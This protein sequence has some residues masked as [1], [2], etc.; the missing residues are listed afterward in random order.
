[1]HPFLKIEGLNALKA[2]IQSKPEISISHKKNGFFVVCALFSDQQT[3]DSFYARECRGITFDISGNL[4]SR[5]LHKFFNLNE[6]KEYT[7]DLIKDKSVYAI[8]EKLDGS[9]IHT[10]NMNG[11]VDFKSKNSFESDVCIE[12]RKFISENVNYY[13]FCEL[14]TMMGLTAIFEYCSPSSRVVINYSKPSLTLL[15]VRDN[16]TGKYVLID[17]DNSVYLLI[18]EY[19]I[20]LVKKVNK[21]FDEI[22]NNVADEK[23]I[24]GYVVQFSDGDMVKVKTNW[25]RDRHK[26]ISFLRERDIAEFA[27]NENLDDVKSILRELGINVAKVEAIESRVKGYLIELKETVDSICEKD[28][29]MDRK[30]FAEK[31]LC[32]PNFSLLMQKYSSKE[33]DYARFYKKNRLNSDFG[34]DS[35]DK[36]EEE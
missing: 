4:V 16:S 22:V 5:P 36:K 23:G 29:K 7:Y 20:P 15:H 28:K 6:V 34:L 13:K 25:Y 10:V 1:M 2:Q 33:P 9:M 30:G 35:I 21:T 27:L 3:Y 19:G 12:A 31:Y 11:K 8:Y 14:V 18:K 32:H 26:I 17:P 24:E